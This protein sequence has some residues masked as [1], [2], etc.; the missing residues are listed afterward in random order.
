MSPDGQRDSDR[1]LTELLAEYD[2]HLATGEAPSPL[3][4]HGADLQPDVCERLR[5]AQ[6]CLNFIESVRSDLSAS[7]LLGNE[8]S[9]GTNGAGEFELPVTIGRFRILR[10][11]G[12][13]GFGVVLLAEDPQLARTVAIKIPRPEA[14]FN[15]SLRRRF[16]REATAVASLCHAGIVPVYESGQ[17]GAL[18]FIV[19]AYCPGISLADWVK[20]SHPIEPRTAAHLV[21]AIAEA[22]EHAHVRGILHRDLKPANILLYSQGE[23][24]SALP[25]DQLAARVRVTDFGLAKC[26]GDHHDTRS[27][28]VIGTAEY[29]PPEQAEGTSRD[30]GPPTDIYSLGA[31]LYELLTGIPPHR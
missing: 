19:S 7:G 5:D 6:A 8:P 3:C 2:E 29:M 11:L 15:N 22:I 26:E 18:C 14:L 31:I 24:L 16:L 27:V 9:S 12:R 23:E 17:S 21:I 28:A 13:G 30:I 20:Q 25:P 10:E 1:V 4:D